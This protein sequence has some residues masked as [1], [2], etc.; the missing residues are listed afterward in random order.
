MD[1]QTAVLTRTMVSGSRRN[2]PMCLAH[3]LVI[4]A[5]TEFE[6]IDGWKREYVNDNYETSIAA[7]PDHT[8]S[9]VM[10]SASLEEWL[11]T[12]V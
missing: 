2:P 10:Q 4:P 8:V 11:P 3:D 1:E 7:G 5:G 12:P 9:I 6:C